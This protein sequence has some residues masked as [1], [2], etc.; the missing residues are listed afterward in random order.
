MDEAFLMSGVDGG[1]DVG[2][3]LEGAIEGGFGGLEVLGDGYA[4]DEVGGEEGLSVGGQAGVDDGDDVGVFDGGESAEVV[5]GDSLLPRDS[6]P[7]ASSKM[8]GYSNLMVTA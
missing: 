2:E 5:G 6:M 7:S 4:L 1:G 8:R 3:E